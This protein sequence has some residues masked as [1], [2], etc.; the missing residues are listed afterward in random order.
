MPHSI[1]ATTAT[2]LFRQGV[3]EQL[4]CETTG[5]KNTTVRTY[6]RSNEAQTLAVQKLLVPKNSSTGNGSE[7]QI[8]TD[9]IPTDQNLG[10]TE[11][12]QTTFN[13]TLS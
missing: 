13:Q 4:I 2:Q 10:I 3:N 6:N 7:M 5:H 8:D 11:S 9:T 1:R 12:S